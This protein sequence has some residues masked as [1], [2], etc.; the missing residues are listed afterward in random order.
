MPQKRK[1]QGLSINTII[2]AIIC[3]I[4]LV[5]IIAI[6]TGRMGSF[7]KGVEETA[8]CENSCM[9]LGD[10]T[11][12]DHAGTAADPCNGIKVAGTYKG[13]TKGCCCT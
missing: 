2:I 1:A 13:I 11:A 10:K 8:T 5:V 9:A 7:S 12:T 6:F 4:V 3:L